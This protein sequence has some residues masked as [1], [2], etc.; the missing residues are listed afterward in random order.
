M[1]VDNIEVFT[2][3]RFPYRENGISFIIHFTGIDYEVP[4]C[5][6]KPSSG[7][8][9]LTGGDNQVQNSAVIRP[10][11]ESLFFEVVPMEMLNTDE[12]TP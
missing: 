11:A 5:T 2:D 6:I 9:P 8:Y 7:E 12:Q 10:F 1:L 3:D 4:L